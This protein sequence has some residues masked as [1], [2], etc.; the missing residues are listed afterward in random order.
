MSLI[1]DALKRAK[2]AQQK[3]APVAPSPQFRP[4]EPAPSR[5][6]GMT[7]PVIIAVVAITALLFVWKSKNKTAEAAAP[8]KPAAPVNTIAETKTPVAAVTAANPAPVAPT[9]A[10]AVAVAPVTSA[11]A[12]ELKLQAIFFAPGRSSAIISGKTVR[13]GNIFKGFRV[14]AITEVSATL[15]SSTQTNV[16][17]LDQ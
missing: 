7:V 15:V 6:M 2:D 14:A 16:M 3:S 10:P 1:N 12:P 8:D 11:P 4:A 17:T 5:G 9:P 13:V